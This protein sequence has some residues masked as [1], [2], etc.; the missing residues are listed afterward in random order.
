MPCRSS[1]RPF[2]NGPGAPGRDPPWD[3]HEPAS[4]NRAPGLK[5]QL[6]K[7]WA[8]P[9]T[10]SI[11]SQGHFLDQVRIP[12]NVGTRL[13]SRSSA[14]DGAFRRKISP[15]RWESFHEC[16]VERAGHAHFDPGLYTYPSCSQ[17][18]KMV[19]SNHGSITMPVLPR[20]AVPD[21]PGCSRQLTINKRGLGPRAPGR[22][23]PPVRPPRQSFPA[24]RVHLLVRPAFSL[25]EHSIN[26]TA[27]SIPNLRSPPRRVTTRLSTR[28]SKR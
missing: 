14:L 1:P 15:V 26:M 13:M 9:H 17:A 21:L 22:P 11:R 18:N 10:L 5:P 7:D 28:N 20:R 3:R 16:R 27:D 12:G 6:P 19:E 4:I 2:G 8:A 25:L 23:S 24:G